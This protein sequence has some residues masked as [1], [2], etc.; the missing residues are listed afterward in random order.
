MAVSGLG[1]FARGFTRRWTA[2]LGLVIFQKSEP[3]AV[4]TI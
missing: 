2:P 4:F 1:R 3:A